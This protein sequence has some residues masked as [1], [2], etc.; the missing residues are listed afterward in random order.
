M[1]T[2]APRSERQLVD[3]D[4][5]SLTNSRAF[6]A[7]IVP[8]ELT[9]HTWS[10]AR[11][12]GD[13]CHL[14]VQQISTRSEALQIAIEYIAKSDTKVGASRSTRAREVE[15]IGPDYRQG[16]DI[17]PE[18][19]M[20]IFGFRGVQFGESLGQAERQLWMNELH[21]ALLDLSNFLGLKPQWIGL[22]GLALAI[23]A[24]GVGGALAH[25]EPELRCFNYTR[26]RGAGSIAHEWWHALDAYLVQ[27]V[28]P[29]YFKYAGGYLSLHE[30]LFD[31]A[32]HAA[33]PRVLGAVREILGY[34][35]SNTPSQFLRDAWKI[36]NLPRQGSYWYQ[37]HE[38][39][40]R[41]FEAYVQDGLAAA[42]HVSPY[43]VLGTSEEEMR[44]E[45]P[46]LR[47]YPAAQERAALNQHF[48][49]LF[50]GLSG[51]GTTACS[52]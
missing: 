8:V 26:K 49:V 13:K 28:A 37:R 30:Q 25:Y 51:G 32:T 43:L 16:V 41:A 17:N 34:T 33:A 52:T 42:G 45:D 19:L 1:D 10:V 6:D 31:L 20:K 3:V 11:I 48:G 29:H 44:A 47:A 14:L 23:G 22:R 50:S 35:W 39:V 18:A 12:E 9:D 40:A 27:W 4:N 24:R 21:D 2:Y 15:R 5:G 7:A 38:L 46:D 36:S